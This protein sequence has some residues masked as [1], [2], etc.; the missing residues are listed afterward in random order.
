MVDPAK[1][2]EPADAIIIE[3]SLL[4]RFDDTRGRLQRP[5]FTQLMSDVEDRNCRFIRVAFVQVVTQ[6]IAIVRPEACPRID[7]GLNA[8]RVDGIQVHDA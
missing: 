1:A 4:G 6:L 5:R 2:V 7:G 8:Q 3:A